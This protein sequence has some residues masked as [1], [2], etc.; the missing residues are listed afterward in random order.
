MDKENSIITKDDRKLLA[1]A[2]NEQVGE[3][4]YPTYAKFALEGN[5]DFTLCALRAIARARIKA[6]KESKE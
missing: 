6:E 4:P 3:G 5:G 2:Y 1:D